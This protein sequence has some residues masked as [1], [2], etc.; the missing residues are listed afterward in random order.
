[1]ITIPSTTGDIG[2]Q[3]S[4]K[5]AAQ[6]V[7]NRQALLQIMSCVR[8]LCRQGLA[9]RGDG[10]ESDSNL[11]QLL[12]MKAEDDPNLKNWLKR[13]ENVYTSPDIQNEIVK[14]MALQVLREITVDLQT[15]PFLTIMADETTDATN[16]EQ[17]TLVLR[18]V[19]EELEVH[20]EFLGLYQVERIDSSTLTAVI[21]DVLM[22]ANI[23]LHKLRGQ[24]YDGASSMSGSKSGV[25][26]QICDIEPRAV[27]T[28]CYGHALNLAAGDTL[29]RS[30]V[31]M[32]ALET[33]R[34]IT[35]L[36]KR[37]PKREALFQSLKDSVVERSPGIRVLCPTRW[38]VRADS[39]TSVISNFDT[40]QSTWEEALT[41]TTDTEA[42]A[43]IRG[44]S[45]QMRTFEF[46]FGA[47]LGEMIL[48][49]TDNL[50][51]TLQHKTI[52]AAEGQE[53]ARMTVETL[54]STRTDESF[55]SF[56]DNVNLKAMSLDIAEPRLP[57]Q[58]K[59]PR[60]FDDGQSSGDIPDTPKSLFKRL[61]YEALDLIINCIE[62]RFDQPGYHVYSRLETLLL[63]AF[64]QGDY[65]EELLAV[66]TFYEDDFNLSNLRTQLQIFGVQGSSLQSS[67]QA[68]KLTI[69]DVKSYFLSLSPG[70]M[71]LLSEV[72][73]L[74]QLILVM[75]ATN[76]TSERSFSAL[77]RV[78]NYLRTTMGQE[79]LNHLMILYV[80][81]SRADSLDLKEIFNNFVAGSQHRSSIFAKF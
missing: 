56:W 28:H 70:Q 71:A 8:F 54:K 74:L 7:K 27:F 18:W 39:L 59:R 37:S 63:K 66:S 15:S 48:R 5:H 16:K 29:K 79:R 9:M 4:L 26:K 67:S 80:H 31:M 51:S 33:T 41:V 62:E 43:R 77:R 25:A 49:H 81:K 12:R 17:V 69:F 76:A 68:A 22:R 32:D 38:T 50:S 47:V 14:V 40:L 64:K 58:H 34:E 36:I 21:K 60:R 6:K 46:F 78:K 23:S 3:L 72:K 42:K 44:I 2:E 30:K 53:I 19:T 55:E 57:R 45:A 24:C 65:E 13:K 1:M 11:H 35:K 52:S 61:Y 73:R 10:D 20:E 75:P